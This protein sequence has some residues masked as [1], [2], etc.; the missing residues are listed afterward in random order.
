MLDTE[1]S[2]T[3]EWREELRAMLAGSRGNNLWPQ[4]WVYLSNML[5]EAQWQQ[6]QTHVDH[7][8]A[9]TFQSNTARS[10]S[11]TATSQST[12]TSSRS[13]NTAEEN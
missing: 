11:N 12:I 5:P 8:L 6:I 9:T 3:P 7:I 13:T 2:N 4:Q 10:Q 1:E